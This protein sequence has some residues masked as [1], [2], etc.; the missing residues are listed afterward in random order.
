MAQIST[1]IVI[2]TYNR[3]YML[4]RTLQSISD[5]EWPSTFV[6]VIVVE[7]SK[8][9]GAAEICAEFKNLPI[10]LFNESKQGLSHAR[11]R[12]F[13]ESNE[14]IIIFFDD[15]VLI[16]NDSLLAYEEEILKYGKTRFYG[17]SLI[18]DYPGMGPPEWLKKH[19]PCS[20]TG[21]LFNGHN[22]DIWKPVFVGTNHAFPRSL[23]V[24]LGGYDHL[25]AYKTGGAVGE[26]TRLQERL[27]QNGIPGRAI[28]HAKVWHWVPDDSCSP[29]WA[30]RRR[31]RHGYTDGYLDAINKGQSTR[32]WIVRLILSNAVS[33][34]WSFFT[35]FDTEER[36]KKGVKL[37]YML[38]YYQGIREGVRDRNN[39]YD[40]RSARKD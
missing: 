23:L 5:A 24:E 28:V 3:P 39:G 18:P 26:E 21:L 16:A 12:G 10:K 11:N 33:F 4:K 20:V 7:N 29:N 36:F 1:S 17:G 25:S 40:Y 30:L 19:L 27:I 9:S 13:L 2:A 38:G 34:A 6:N 14:D 8:P 32:P 35:S 22:K 37:Q 31:R 15:D